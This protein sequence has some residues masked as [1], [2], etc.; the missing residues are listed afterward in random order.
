V[1]SDGVVEVVVEGCAVGFVVFFVWCVYSCDRCVLCRGKGDDSL[2]VFY[3]VESL[4]AYYSYSSV[5]VPLCCDVV[6]L[7]VDGAFYFFVSRC[8]CKYCVLDVVVLHVYGYILYS[9]CEASFDV[10]C[11][12]CCVW[13]IRS[14]SCCAKL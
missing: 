6:F 11:G 13:V 9:V 2:L 5:F 4:C 10:D 8:F 1:L 14:D 7:V 3:Y 12:Y